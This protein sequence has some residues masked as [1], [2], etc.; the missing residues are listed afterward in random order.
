MMEIRET[1]TIALDDYFQRIGYQGDRSP[2]LQTLTAIHYC[3]TQ[4]IAFENLSPLLRQP[5]LLDLNSLQNKLVYSERGGYCYEQNL[6]FH[7]ALTA[8]GFTVKG[9]AARVLWGFPAGII[10]PRTHMVLLV[11]V[12][13]KPYLADVGFGGFTLTTPLA[14]EVDVEQPTPHEPFRLVL[15]NQVYVMQVYVAQ[16]WQSIYCFDL[17]EQHLPDYE[18]S[19][20][21]VST[22]PQ[23]LLTNSLLAARPDPHC[24]Y[25]L[26]DNQFKIYHLNGKIESQTLTTV[27]ELGKVLTNEFRL[28]LPDHP[29]LENVLHQLVK[30]AASDF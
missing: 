29:D 10:R 15:S 23:S 16:E 30:S 9:L 4:A 12:Q 20:W 27:K 26:R 5:V 28:T 7:S 25:T 8:L 18:V 21:Y 1:T 2:T 13:G 19:N 24:R 22:H 6:L 3:H 14:F 17:Q 11:T